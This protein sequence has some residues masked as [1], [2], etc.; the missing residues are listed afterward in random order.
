MQLISYGDFEGVMIQVAAQEGWTFCDG[1]EPVAA[2]TVFNDETYGPAILKVAATELQVRG[3]S[4]NL[5]VEFPAAPD[6]LLGVGVTF[7]PAS[8]SVLAATWRIC[9]ASYVIENLPKISNDYDL[10]LLRNVFEHR[11]EPSSGT[12]AVSDQ[13]QVVA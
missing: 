4:A 2:E 12:P 9:L 6:A 8:N 13:A 10:S 3:F 5:G 7:D 1:D 11:P